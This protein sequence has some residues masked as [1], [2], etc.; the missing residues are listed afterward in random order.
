MLLYTCRTLRCRNSSIRSQRGQLCTCAAIAFS[1]TNF[2]WFLVRMKP[3]IY[4]LFLKPSPV[5]VFLY[6][7][8]YRHLWL[9]LRCWLCLCPQTGFATDIMYLVFRPHGRQHCAPTSLLLNYTNLCTY[10]CMYVSAHFSF[11]SL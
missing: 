6:L 10:M 3:F 7:L 9:C 4:Y 1:S 8:L 5:L 11:Y 2:S